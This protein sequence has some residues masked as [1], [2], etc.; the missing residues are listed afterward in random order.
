MSISNKIKE[1]MARGS[2][3]RRMF[4]E[5]AVLKQRYGAENVFDLSLGNP[6]MEPPAEFRRELKRLVDQPSPGMH[7]YMENA[8]YLETRDAV[9]KQLQKETGIS[10]SANDIL[11]TCGAAGAMNVVLKTILNPGEEVILFAPFFVEYLNYVDNHG[12]VVKILPTDETFVP[13]LDKLEESIGAGTRAL[14]INSPNNPTGVVY[15][16]DFMKALGQL[17]R[18]K[19]AQYGTQ[20]FLIADE[21]YRKI[22]FDGLEYPSPFLYYPSTIVATSHSKDLALPGERIGYL[23]VHPQCADHDDLMAGAIYCNRILGFV[24]APALMQHIVQHLQNV[25]ISVADYQAKRDLLYG[26]LTRMGYSLVRP[27]GAFYMFPKSPIPDDV[28]FVKELAQFK[29]LAVPGSGFGA[30]GYFRLCYCVDDATIKGA[31]KGFEQ[32]ARKFGIC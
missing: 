1:N 23:A 31:L 12:G 16:K 5:G 9:A 30:P 25:T 11:M 13:R 26:S 21:P 32:A 6:I 22:I 27:Q 24:N 2:W 8:G 17:L 14:I 20:I 29:V 28:A 4:E 3:I 7:R 10:F 15:S 19:E 18:K